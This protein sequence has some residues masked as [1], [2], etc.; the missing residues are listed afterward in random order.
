[1]CPLKRVKSNFEGNSTPPNAAVPVRILREVLLVVVG[2]E[3]GIPTESARLR[4]PW[5]VASPL[6][7]DIDDRPVVDIDIL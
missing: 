2:A 5:L 7:V 1:M 3:A 4:E 6:P